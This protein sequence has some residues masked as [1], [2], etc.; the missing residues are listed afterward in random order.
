M[1]QLLGCVI[2]ECCNQLKG[3][4]FWLHQYPILER[5]GFSNA[6]QGNI[7]RVTI[8]IFLDVCICTL[9]DCFFQKAILFLLLLHLMQLIT[10]SLNYYNIFYSAFLFINIYKFSCAFQM[11]VRHRTLT[12]NIKLKTYKMYLTIWAKQFMVS[13]FVNWNCWTQKFT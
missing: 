11:I 5:G 9:V 13:S 1:A 3:F 2:M 7:L 10:L 4:T 6:I 8:K 12:T